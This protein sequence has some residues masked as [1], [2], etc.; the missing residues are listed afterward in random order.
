M[1]RTTELLFSGWP[2]LL[3][4]DASHNFPGHVQF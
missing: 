1:Q 2:P 3:A 4:S